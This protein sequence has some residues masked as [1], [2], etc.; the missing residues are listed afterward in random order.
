MTL[1]P[2]RRAIA[3][4][5]SM[6]AGCPYR[7]TGRMARVAGV[8]A[9]S[10]RA[11][12]RLYLRASGSTGTGVAPAYDT[13]SHVAMYVFEGTMTSSPGP[14]PIAFRMMNRASSP[15]ATPMQ[16]RT[17]Q[18]AANS[19]SNA[20]TSFPR[21]SQFE[22]TTRAN[23]RSSWGRISLCIASK[24][25]NGIIAAHLPQTPR[26]ESHRNRGCNR[27]RRNAQKPAP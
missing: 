10:I 16:W 1:S 15:F 7:C 20:C 9:A 8:I 6:S 18:Y 26:Q 17:P 3:M 13:A 25:R 4:M 21:I 2:W 19:A 22:S 11:G 5:G 27:P 14:I 12:S 24:S 23:A